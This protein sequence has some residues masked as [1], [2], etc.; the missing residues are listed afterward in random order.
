MKGLSSAAARFGV[1]V[2]VLAA[3]VLG[4]P[5]AGVFWAGDPVGRY[6]Q[7]PPQT[8]YVRHAPF[9]W[10]IFI[11]I[12]GMVLGVAGPVA[13]AAFKK[14]RNHAG[15]TGVKARHPFPWWGWAGVVSGIA[16]WILAW[17]RFPWFAAFQPH[18]FTPLWL[19]YIIV[20]NA[21]CV[22][23]S[24]DCL[25]TRRPVFFISLFPASA[26]FWWL[27]EYLNRFV[28]NWYYTG[29]VFDRGS[30]FWFATLC[31]ATVLPAVLSTRR[32]L[33]GMRWVQRGFGDFYPLRFSRP[34][35]AAAS[36]LL[37]AAGGL[38]GIGVW[39]DGL[40][41]LLWVS[42][43]LIVVSLKT[44]TGQRHCLEE[45]AAGDWR[46]A[47]A[48]V[49]AALVCGWFWEMWN[50]YSLAKWKYSIPFVQRFL[51]FEMPALGYAGY[52]PFGLECMVFGGLVEELN[53][54]FKTG[55]WP[56]KHFC[57]AKG[58]KR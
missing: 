25:M 35:W 13:L 23:Q 17:S 43:L 42:P 54:V 11:L 30:Y 48:G 55:S 50:Y 26:A 15:G 14:Y 33:L 24:G 31:F 40:F 52:L 46:G 57:Q 36:V 4:L 27:F 8:L 5:L 53:A 49:A 44:L 16:A 6:L 28:Q 39:P 12:A 29:V 47:A 21:L 37:L 20:V 9:S 3:M 7:F 10:P 56:R 41:P 2:L 58:A 1:Q 32:W 34:R 18:T 45:M 19:S 22:R 38:T 51:I